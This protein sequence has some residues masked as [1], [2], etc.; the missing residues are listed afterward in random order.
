[1]IERR[2]QYLLNLVRR[3]YQRLSLWRW[4]AV[5]WAVA[6]FVVVAAGV[7]SSGALLIYLA[8]WR[9]LLI[10]VGAGLAFSLWRSQH[11]A[12]DSQWLARKIEQEFPNLEARLLTATENLENIDPRQR[13]YLQQRVIREAVDHGYKYAWEQTVSSPRL[14]ASQFMHWIALGLFL[15]SLPM[16]QR[17]D[18][19]ENRLADAAEIM[20]GDEIVRIEPGDAKVER[21]TGL[22]VVAHFAD[23]LPRQVWLVYGGSDSQPKKRISLTRSLDDPAFGGR[24]ENIQDDQEYHVEFDGRRSRDF[25]VSVFEYPRLVRADV[26]LTYPEYTELESNRI[27]D[28]HRVTA[29]EGTNLQW[30]LQLNKPVS[31]A[32]LEAEDGS[33]IEP[34]TIDEGGE[35]LSVIQRL[36]KSGRYKL[37]LTDAEGR[38]NKDPAELVVEVLPNRPPELKVAF[39]QG[40]RAVSP[41]EE[42]IFEASAW[43]DFG[44]RAVGIEYTLG[45]EEPKTVELLSDVPAKEK[46]Q[47]GHLLAMESL[48][49]QPDQLL[50][51]TIWADDIGPDDSPRRT[52][53][54]I[55]FAEVRRFDEIFREGQQPPGGAG[56]GGA[57]A[58]GG[59]GG[60]SEQLAQ[61][62]KQ[63]V[64]ATWNLIRRETGESV[65]D[66]FPADVTTIRDS[67]QQALEQAT[68]MQERAANSKLAPLV[69]DVLSQMS[70][71]VE[72]LTQ[73][74]D[75]AAVKSLDEALVVERQA[76]QALL[77]LRAKE[78]L[79]TRGQPGG[80][81][82]GGGGASVSQ[83]Q[84]QQLELNNDQ[85]RYETERQ[86]QSQQDAQRQ[87][88]TEVLDRLRE[89]ARR[90]EDINERVKELQLALQAAQS[91]KERAE[92]ER[93]LKRLR[94]EQERLLRDV[95]ELNQRMEQSDNQ[96]QWNEQ[97][98]Q[99]AETRG[100]VLQAS[101]ALEQ[102]QLSE[103]TSAGTR[104]ERQ[105]DELR[106]DFRR[107]S[108]SQ[109]R[110]TMQNLR[111]QAR[112]LSDKQ[113]ESDELLDTIV[114]PEQKSLRGSEEREQFS[115]GAAGQR[116]RLESI[117]NRM[118]DITMEAE[119]AEPLLSKQL[120]DTIRETNQRRIPENL[121]Q[122]ATWVQRGFPEEARPYQTQ[123]TTDIER[124]RS[125][126]ER[127][128]E[129]IL[130]DEA[131]SLRRASDELEDLIRQLE[132]EAPSDR[133]ADSERGAGDQPRRNEPDEPASPG[134][135]ATEGD[136]SDSSR[137]SNGAR[138][139]TDEQSDAADSAPGSPSESGNPAAENESR[140]NGDSAAPR[141]E[142][143]S[144]E[145]S[146][147][148]SSPGQPE[149]QSSQGGSQDSPDGQSSQGSSG[150]SPDDSSSPSEGEGSGSSEPAGWQGVFDQLAERVR[151]GGGASG[152]GG[153]ITGEDFRQWSDRM[154]DVEDMIDNPELRAEIARLRGRAQQMRADYR[155]NSQEPQWDLLR[156][157]VIEPMEEL[158]IRIDEELAK[159]EKTKKHVPIDRDPVPAQFAEHVR[160]YYEQ[161]SRDGE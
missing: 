131:E 129:D 156:D 105:L 19:A 104:A 119:N 117:L 153:P 31:T 160:R 43:D 61:L 125:G 59:S 16:F 126:I 7:A 157:T 51:Y 132:Q 15:A 75:A 2:L 44:I 28:T 5:T 114:E 21:G 87:E 142:E 78:H 94:E 123:A 141:S 24:I 118:R 39:P 128:A 99:L 145:S 134:Q 82:G 91:E 47:L 32:Y 81:G 144:N 97:R 86:A 41:L 143:P 130:G 49:A 25:E 63:I 122:A 33:R 95:D 53:S 42:V 23:E 69:A 55:Y 12:Q 77:R 45:A 121:A 93:R 124:L 34:E 115:Q 108:S 20:A 120:Y 158:Q 36:T 107:Q 6:A 154:R 18:V 151:T 13:S 62:Q 148:A 67:Q 146:S 56:G 147:P 133:S 29:V 83:Q 65:S 90:Q 84:L 74:L 161:L 54:D 3:R 152:P 111:R 26:D 103:A 89:L 8:S 1:M 137:G 76:Y 50:S 72:N 73:A 66:K 4:L 10:V 38:E 52:Y 135:T 109:F 11:V 149:S 60:M 138:E 68:A 37:K 100:N 127:A 92:L 106:Q 155:R 140:T 14:L 85:N 150:D 17:S 27:E 70:L 57:P 48:D 96:S 110:E 30:S 159:L 98:E 112:E 102:G 139:S 136:S 58:G 46:K 71:A 80:G 64:T 101:E 35:L 9:G 40:D 22:M 79:V 116:E 113:Q 88:Q